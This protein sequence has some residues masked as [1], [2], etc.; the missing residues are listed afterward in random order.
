M[1]S[2]EQLI[3][4]PFG[5]LDDDGEALDFCPSCSGNGEC[6]GSSETCICDDGFMLTN[7]AMEQTT[8]DEMVEAMGAISEVVIESFDPDDITDAELQSVL[9]IIVTSTSSNL[10]KIDVAYDMSSVLNQII[11]GLSLPDLQGRRRLLSE[12][13]I[14]N[15]VQFM[16]KEIID[17]KVSASKIGLNQFTPN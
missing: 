3:E 16:K 13:A 10:I 12:K 15:E 11:L 1:T 5:T 14:K 2:V 17:D 9:E 6:G 7:C 4:I 8:H